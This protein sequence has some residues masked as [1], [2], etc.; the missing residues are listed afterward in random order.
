MYNELYEAWKQERESADLK[1]LPRDFYARLADYVKKQREETRMMDQK[2]IRGQLLQCELKNAKKM[3]KD[4]AKLRYAKALRLTLAGKDVPKDILAGEE[5]IYSE[6]LPTIE[7]FKGFLKGLE[8]GNLEGGLAERTV[9]K[10]GP[11]RLVVRFVQEI[12][13]IIGSDM[14]EYG[15]FKPEDIA[16]LPAENAR[17]LVKQGAAVE[18]EE[19]H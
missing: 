1:T 11:K 6:M 7:L 13:A 12:P 15:P 14:K 9:Q 3:I 17:I 16:T 19:L 2:T 18:I 8:K 4:I 10:V 5:R